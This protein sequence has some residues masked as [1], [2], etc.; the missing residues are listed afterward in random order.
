[1]TSQT[2]TK[3]GG[4]Q[5]GL[6]NLNYSYQAAAG[7]MGTGTTAGNAEQLMAINNN[8]T[9]N[10]T[11]E[12]AAYTYDLERRLVTS[13]QT[14]NG[15]SAQRRFAYDRWGNRTGMWDGTSGG[16]QIQAV[17][18]QQS[19]GVPTNRIQSVTGN[20]AGAYSYDAAG[21]LTGDGVHTYQYDGENRLRTVDSATTAAYAYDYQNRRF[22]K[23]VGSVV[24]HYIWDGDHVLAEHNGT[25]GAQIID[26]VYSGARL[27]GEGPGNVLGGNGTFTF[28]LSDRLSTRVSVDKYAN[29]L[30]RQAHLPFGEEF[31]ETGTQEKHH[32]T[33][34]ES[35]PEIGSDYAVNRQFAE[36]LGRFAPVDPMS[37]S[38]SNP[39][40]LNRYSYCGNDPINRTDSLGLYWICIPGKEPDDPDQCFSVPD[41]PNDDPGGSARPNKK[42]CK[43]FLRDWSDAQAA[44]IA[45]V[46]AIFAD[47]FNDPS[48]QTTFN[49]LVNSADAD[50]SYGQKTRQSFKQ[51][52]RQAANALATALARNPNDR[53]VLDALSD[54]TLAG[55]AL[56]SLN[57]AADNLLRCKGVLDPPLSDEVDS[58]A[59]DG[60]GTKRM[61]AI[62]GA[63][64]RPL[65]GVGAVPVD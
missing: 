33:S 9:I 60:L 55:L 42:Q 21:N 11:A 62:Y 45:H 57:K 56:N 52:G 43:Q 61:N 10:G 14:T 12:S 38:T 19:S 46:S 51:Y 16:N 24:T 39:Q 5:G 48:W 3:A 31:G 36:T 32:F 53:S 41:P 6:L 47:A 18:L 29:I 13:S 17:T 4:A 30:G 58:F 37:G 20:G 1:L 64:L 63:F 27:I 54:A 22:K 34:Y 7:Q 50:G 40:K 44:V 8:S 23:A 65:R 15:S 49:N 28:L 2:A 35:D 25:N 26:Y 59:S